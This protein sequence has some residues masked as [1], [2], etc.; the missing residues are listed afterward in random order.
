MQDGRQQREK[1]LS[2]A[3]EEATRTLGTGPAGSGQRPWSRKERLA[4]AEVGAVAADMVS[5]VLGRR[6]G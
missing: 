2:Q 1:I 4:A 6:V 5:K 3:R